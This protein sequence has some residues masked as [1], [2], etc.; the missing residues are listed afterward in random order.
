MIDLTTPKG[1]AERG[2]GNPETGGGSIRLKI[3]STLVGI[4][5]LGGAAAG[6]ALT[7]LGN[8]ISGYPITPGIGVYAWN[9]GIMGGLGAVFGP[10]VAW[11]MLRRVPLWRTLTEPALAGI[12]GSVVA[13]LLAP[14]LFP[15][16]VPGAILASS[17][18]LRY[19]YRDRSEVKIPASP[20]KGDPDVTSD[21]TAGTQGGLD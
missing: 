17:V 10:P 13:M 9:M 14:P 21:L 8:V 4:G 3:T 12:G 15:I 5:A 7:Y 11:T 20:E 6:L 19:A 2:T 18:R 1:N 16:L